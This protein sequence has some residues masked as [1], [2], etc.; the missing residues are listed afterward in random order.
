MALNNL[1]YTRTTLYNLTF[2]F[3][4]SLLIMARQLKTS[5]YFSC[6]INDVYT[7]T[8]WAWQFTGA[9]KEGIIYPRWTSL[10]F[11]GYG[12]PTFILYSPLSFYLVA[13]FN[14]FTGS[15]ITAMNI[16]K[17]LSLFL[18]ATGMFFLLR[19]FYSERIALLSSSFYILFPYTI[20]GLY[21]LGGFAST[22]SFM[23]FSPI[24]L[25]T[26]RYLERRRYKCI[27]YAGA[28]YGGLILTHLLNA[29]MFTFVIVTF[30]IYMS[31]VNKRSKSMISI[32]VL[33]TT[34][35][36]ISAAYILPLVYEKQFLNIRGFIGEGGGFHFADFFIL[37]NMTIKQDPSLL[38]PVYYNTF[39]FYVF[40]F[41]T[42]LCLFLYQTL[43]LRNIEVVEKAKAVTNFF[44]G[45][46]AV[47]IFLLFGVS[48]FLWET[49]PFFKYIQFPGRWFHITAFAVIFLSAVTFLTPDIIRNKKKSYSFIFAMFIIILFSSCLILDY[50][51]I[52]YACLFT[53]QELLP[54]RTVDL[55][56]EHLPA[57]VNINK[58]DK[59]DNRQEKVII[60]EGEGKAAIEIWQSA[61]KIIEI[62]AK[63]Q[64]SLRIRI[65]NFPGWQAYIDG[66]N[67][68]LRTEENTGA[69]L[70]DIPEGHHFLKLTFEDTPIRYFS[71]W[72]SFFSLMSVV[73]IFLID[74]LKIL[75]SKKAKRS[76]I[77]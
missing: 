40:F 45:V 69:M 29:Y 6:T 56:H 59:D 74:C 12:S 22:I 70:I 15:I 24:L 71:K 20:F 44:F 60:K 58:I 57:W 63:N 42:L 67:K 2:L 10:N 68:E 66:S 53:E 21:L 39:V 62:T 8:S 5:G 3:V 7:Y 32:F 76:S 31:I 33:I 37:P 14:V 50:K 17:F 52:K 36:L 47:S 28:C 9:L 23:W 64:L 41:I 30:I 75:L 43:R 73:T 19:E 77:L 38:W 13:F 46:A 26:H 35:L 61:E 1:N 72:I 51:Y 16:T 55:T 4:L 54:V 34:G 18:S 49:I 48:T 27:F 25:F 65:F 11:W